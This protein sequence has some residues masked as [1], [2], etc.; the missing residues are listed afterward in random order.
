MSDRVAFLERTR[1]PASCADRARLLRLA[2]GM[3]ARRDPLRAPAAVRSPIRSPIR[4]RARRRRRRADAG[5]HL[6]AAGAGGAA[7]RR[8]RPTQTASARR[9]PVGGSAAGWTAAGGT[10]V[11]VGQGETLDTLSRRYG[12]PAAALLAPTAFRARSEVKSGMHMVVPVYTPTAAA[13]AQRRNRTSREEARRG[14]RRRRRGGQG[15]Q[16]KQG[17]RREDSSAKADKAA[18]ETRPSPPSKDD[19]GGRGRLRPK[20]GQAGARPR[21]QRSTR[22][23]PATSNPA[24]ARRKVPLTAA[25]ADAVG[26]RAR[27][28][29]AGARPHHRGLQG[30]R[31]RRHQ[32]LGAVRDLGPGGR[33]RR[34]R[35]F[36]RRAQGLRQSRADQAS[37][38]ASSPPTPTTANSTSSAARQV[39]RGQVIA[40]S[41]DTGNVNAPQLHFELRKGSTPVDPTNYLAGL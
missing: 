34:R 13:V 39:K 19:A 41:G 2:L 12:V 25:K 4:S 37:R 23:R 16:G 21:S 3:F 8:R 15:R 7:Q 38:T 1:V 29:L 11:V 28:P 20:P 9:R 17:Q 36:G 32:H 31:Q 22:R 18:E 24:Q 14:R 26:R 33:E 27:I 5:R 40:K 30:R 35:L 10:P 6:R